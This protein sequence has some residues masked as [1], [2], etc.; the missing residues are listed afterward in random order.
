MIMPIDWQP[1]ARTKV[2][3]SSSRFTSSRTA[4]I[5]TQ[6]LHV[7]EAMSDFLN[8]D[9]CV[10][11]YLGE[12]LQRLSFDV[13][14]KYKFMIKS[15]R[16]FTY[17][18]R[19]AARAVRSTV[20]MYPVVPGAEA[21]GNT[22]V[23]RNIT[24]RLIKLRDIC[25]KRKEK[26]PDAAALK[27]EAQSIV[28]SAVQGY[29]MNPY[30]VPSDTG[31]VQ[32]TVEG[33][34]ISTCDIE[35]GDKITGVPLARFPAAAN[36]RPQLSYRSIVGIPLQI[37]VPFGGFGGF[38][39][40]TTDQ[41]VNNCVM[42]LDDGRQNVYCLVATT[43]IAHGDNIICLCSRDPPNPKLVLRGKTVAQVLDFCRSR[44]EQ[45][46]QQV[47][48]RSRTAEFEKKSIEEQESEAQMHE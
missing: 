6:T 34:L 21:F 4:T 17:P 24:S 19:E 23:I 7:G 42:S 5:Q 31:K 8:H 38:A 40:F 13:L 36:N 47:L 33:R 3:G 25:E 48:T 35:V 16:V 39:Q 41:R 44:Q 11:D 10:A 43:H 27:K 9:M 45:Q 30:T 18:V 12:G 22:A 32:Y 28:D 37:M 2:S 29:Q 15:A 1:S 46:E 20:E 14:D 26:M